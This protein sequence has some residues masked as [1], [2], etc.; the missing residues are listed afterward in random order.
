MPLRETTPPVR[1]VLFTSAEPLYLPGYLEPV[2][3]AHAESVDRVVVA[4][5]DAPLA[6]ELRGQLG[7]Y[8][9]RAGARMGLRY[10]RSRAL[11]LLPGDLAQ[12]WTGRHHSV[13][14]VADVHGVQLERVGD[15]GDPA[16]VERIRSREPDLLLS[17]VAGQRLPRSL[18]ETAED[19]INLHGSLLPEYRGRA[20]AF[21]PLYYGDDRTGVTAHRMTERFDA[22]PILERR[23]F[24]IAP[25]DTV[26]SIYRKL[27]ATGAAL[28]VDLLDGYP[29]L[30]AEHPNETTA[31][32]Y[33]GLPGPEER[34][35]FRERGNAFL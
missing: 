10:A 11:D 1:V 3:D 26:D 19:A 27:A 33:H 12:K 2:L 5:F 30:P 15:V 34:R 32:D 7:M 14:S 21:W 9:V 24:P 6:E 23:A 13:R 17:V 29:D 22:G 31:A 28:A 25:G 20:T 16:F 35:A 4:P 8:G 18:L